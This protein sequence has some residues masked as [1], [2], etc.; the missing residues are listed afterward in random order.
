M[1]QV[2]IADDPAEAHL[3]AGILDQDGISC[4]IR[5]EDLWNARGQ[6][7]LTAETLPTVWIVDDSK[8][9]QAVELV[10]Q[11]ED[12]TLAADKGGDPWTCPNC[13]E[14]VEAQFSNCWQCRA[15]RPPETQA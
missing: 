3:V 8:Y 11:F 1:K 9:E 14:E 4:D 15:N 10:K 12:R 6:L 7:P 13:G 2:Y 5:G